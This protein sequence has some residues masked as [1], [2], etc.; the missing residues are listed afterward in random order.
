MIEKL[1]HVVGFPVAWVGRPLDFSP[2]PGMTDLETLRHVQREFSEMD[3]DAFDAMWR[4]HGQPVALDSPAHAPNH[5]SP[6]TCDSQ[7]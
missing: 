4:E 3:W 1:I 6:L 5:A 7:Q 2:F